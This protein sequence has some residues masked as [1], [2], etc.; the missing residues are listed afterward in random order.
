MTSSILAVIVAIFAVISSAHPMEKRQD[1]GSWSLYAYGH[2]I[3]GLPIF[4][5][6][7]QA[8][9]GDMSLSNATNK[10][11]FSLTFG[12]N[13]RTWVAHFDNTTTPASNTTN[14]LGLSDTGSMACPVVF[15]PSV[16]ASNNSSSLSTPQTDV[17]TLYGKYVVCSQAKVNFYAQPTGQDGWYILLW[18]ATADA[19]LKNIPV[20][21]RTIGPA[22][23]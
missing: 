18:S 23:G 12:D 6:D 1:D 21:L 3:D 11:A 16:Q 15:T 7:G 13:Q 10:F 17:W 4:Y 19:A 5:A 22:S 20:T 8:Q 9:I 14:L 2:N